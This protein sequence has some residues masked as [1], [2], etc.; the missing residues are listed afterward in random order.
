MD[1]K[2]KWVIGEDYELRSGEK[3][4]CIYVMDHCDY[5]VFILD[6]E[7]VVSRKTIEGCTN[8]TA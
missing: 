4:K 1:N 5:P 8:F 2:T 7:D 6:K 3:V